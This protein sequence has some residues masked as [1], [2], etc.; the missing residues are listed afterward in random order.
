MGCG[1]VITI[2]NRIRSGLIV[3]AVAAAGMAVVASS[4]PTPARAGMVVSQN[5]IASQIGARVLEEGGTA[6]DAAVATAFALAVVHPSAGN[7]GGGGFLVYRPSTGEPVAYDFRE[8]APA[9]ATATMFLVDG[10]YR[11]DVHHNGYLSVGV[12]GTVAGLHLAWKDSGKLPWRRLIDPAIALA[13][14]GF[15]VSEG[16]ARSL[17]EVVR[18]QQMQKSP[19]AVAQFSKNGTSYTAGETFKQPD[20]ARTLERIG[21]Q[22]PAGFYEGETARLIEKEMSSHDGL[23]TAADLKQ[24]VAKKRTP[25]AGSYRG[26]DI[27]SMPPPTSGG[28]ALVEM[29]NILEG[30][31]LASLGAG[32]AS[33]I[34]LMTEA[35]R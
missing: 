4:V 8:V 6:I 16:L 3:I 20:L 12:P 11:S 28:V 7:I 19:A 14:D 25:I 35:M 24:Y 2:H 1:M 15:P 29:L 13:R 26:Y 10:K 30:Y 18:G 27:I 31:D 34:H 22:G 17:R 32:S 23:I 33:S 5:Q 21:S 9:K